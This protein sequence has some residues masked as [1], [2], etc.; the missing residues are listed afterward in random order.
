MSAVGGA[1]GRF[2]AW[3]EGRRELLREEQERALEREARRV[4]EAFA[5]SEGGPQEEIA[6][7][8]GLRGD[9][10]RIAQLLELNG[11][12]RWVAFEERFV[13][14]V[15]EPRGEILAALRYRAISRRRLLL[16]LLVCDPRA[17]ERSLATALYTGAGELARELSV[18]EV[19]A[20][21]TAAAGDYPRVAGYRRRE[22]GWLLDPRGV[23]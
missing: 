21:P 18:A 5:A 9:E 15:A 1:W 13:V 16:G 19:L 12:P 4:R 11:M 20:Q 22:S 8:W 14:A 6:V 17:E 10:G 3:R 2:L 23:R 7:R